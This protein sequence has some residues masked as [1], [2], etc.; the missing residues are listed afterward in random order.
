MAKQY[1]SLIRLFEHCSIPYNDEINLLRIRKQ[2]QAEFGFSA[3]GM[4]EVEGYTYNK[5]DVFEELEKTDFLQRLPYH[6]GI[7]E[8]KFILA[9]LE[10][11]AVN[12]P[13]LKTQIR[14]YQ[15]NLEF[16]AFFSPYFAIPFN[17]ISRSYL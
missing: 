17:V 11:H 13:D 8:N 3:S 12:L 9:I 4:I 6:I 1:T 16:E 15:D 7:W 2:L 5:N 10:D 14:K